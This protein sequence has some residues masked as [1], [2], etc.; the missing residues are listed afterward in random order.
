MQDIVLAAAR[1]IAAGNDPVAGRV[2][3]LAQVQADPQVQAHVNTASRVVDIMNELA[4]AGFVYM[5]C[6]H[7]E[8][9][10]R[11]NPERED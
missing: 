6:R 5:I 4:L 11:V 8:P 2:I 3:S 9:R 1:R 10:W 7:P